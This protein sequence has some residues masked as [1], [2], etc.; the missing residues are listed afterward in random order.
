MEI[1]LPIS[2][3]LIIA[4]GSVG[5]TVSISLAVYLVLKKGLDNLSNILLILF[6][7]LLGLTLLNDVL[8]S[9]G[10]TNTF[11]NLYFIPITYSLSLSPLFYLF[12]KSKHHQSVSSSDYLHLI[13]P[14]AQA[15]F[16]F[17]VGFQ[18]VAYKGQLW[19]TPFFKVLFTIETIL[20]PI[21]LLV[22]GFLSI[23]SLRQP[24]SKTHFWSKDID[25]WLHSLIR[26]FIVLAILE[27]LVFAFEWYG[28]RLQATVYVVRIMIFTGFILWLAS[29]VIKLFFP[30]MIYQTLPTKPSL[31]ISSDEVDTIK[32]SII[33]LM[34]VDNIYLNPDLNLRM[35]SDYVGTTPK[36]CSQ[37]LQSE[38]NKNF[39]QFINSYRINA[40]K[41]KL[42]EGKHKEYTLLSLAYDSGFDSKSTFNRSF[43]LV[44]GLS[45]SQYIKSL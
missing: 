23:H 7:L 24:V 20:F 21:G 3:L 13:L 42:T 34:E 32:T 11:K 41:Q 29:N 14:I 30:S 31:P 5:I 22:Y 16:Y 45:P 28:H 4:I 6:F 44:T 15:A 19:A 36:K 12:I 39:N 27:T 1:T 35:L 26:S 17:Y 25:H 8:L 2:S 9:S 43:K 38:L 10:I 37:I 33:K 40:F 18:S